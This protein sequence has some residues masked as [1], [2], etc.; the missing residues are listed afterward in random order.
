MSRED[1]ALPLITL[2]DE[3]LSTAELQ[4]RRKTGTWVA[5]AIAA[6]IALQIVYSMV[7]NPG[8]GWGVVGRYLFAP[9]V[10]AGLLTTLMLTAVSMTTAVVL[11]VV[12][13]V[14]ADSKNFVL[15]SIARFFVWIFR[16]VPLLV[17][18]IFCYNL[19][20]LYPKLSLGLPF[21]SPFFEIKTNA[22]ITSLGAAFIALSLNEAAYMAEIVRSGLGSVD[23][24]QREAARVLGM[25]AWKTF[26]RII[27]PQ[28]MRVIIPPTGN[29][30]ISMLKYTSLVSV[31]ALPEL[32]Y[33]TQ[34]ISSQN[35]EVIPMLMVAS[36]WYLI[37]TTVLMTIQSRIER[38][39]SRSVVRI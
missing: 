37:V 12:V 28:A 3:Q 4:P 31:I 32:L 1:I 10:I 24:G 25:S 15:S 8:F 35:F 9:Q 7:T 21:F 18:I 6:L 16:A 27:L 23:H 36:I 34:L 20:A 29:E 14:C 11:G 19:A 39:F 22:V 13:A 5:A 2:T 38:R 30:A 33:S 26:S 17:Q